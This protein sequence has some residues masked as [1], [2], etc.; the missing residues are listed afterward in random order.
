MPLAAGDAVTLSH[1][2]LGGYYHSE[3]RDVA[4]S[5]LALDTGELLW[6]YVGTIG[7]RGDSVQ[8]GTHTGFDLNLSSA[9]GLRIQ[10][11]DPQVAGNTGIDNIRFD[12]GTT[13]GPAALPEPATVPLLALALGGLAMQRRRAR[14]A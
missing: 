6:S 11:A 8:T 4:V 9:T 14:A 2:D 10:W 12:V 3:R 7:S 13:A 5:V 1:F